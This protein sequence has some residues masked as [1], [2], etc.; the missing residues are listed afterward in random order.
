MTVEETKQLELMYILDE[1][2]V[3]SRGLSI[4]EDRDSFTNNLSQHL[5]KII[6][7]FQKTIDKL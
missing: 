4:I 6:D 5:S 2:K 3:I 1:L 7:K